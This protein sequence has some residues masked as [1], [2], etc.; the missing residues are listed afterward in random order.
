MSLVRE[1]L[2]QL[3]LPFFAAAVLD[4]GLYYFLNT[5]YLKKFSDAIAYSLGD[6]LFFLHFN[7]L[8]QSLTQRLTQSLIQ[9][10]S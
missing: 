5:C 6:L 10:H 2:V 1:E 7:N 4:C 8:T 3:L 9:S